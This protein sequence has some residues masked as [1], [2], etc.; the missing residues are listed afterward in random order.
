MKTGELE[1]MLLS[2]GVVDFGNE[3]DILFMRDLT[4]AEIENLEDLLCTHEFFDLGDKREPW[5]SRELHVDQGAFHVEIEFIYLVEHFGNKE[6]A[7]QK[8]R[9]LLGEICRICEIKELGIEVRF[10]A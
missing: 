10:R 1:E 6:L 4:D 7:I 8:L 3:L 2:D 9:E 5:K